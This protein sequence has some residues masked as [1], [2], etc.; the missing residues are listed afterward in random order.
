MK[1]V[2]YKTDAFK[3]NLAVK[4]INLEDVKK[5]KLTLPFNQNDDAIHF[6]SIGN[7][8][9]DAHILH[10]NNVF[11]ACDLCQNRIRKTTG[12]CRTCDFK[13]TVELEDSLEKLKSWLEKQEAQSVNVRHA[14]DETF[15]KYFSP[16]EIT[17]DDDFIEE[18]KQELSKRAR[19]AAQTRRYKRDF[20][21]IC[22]YG[23][24]GGC[25]IS[26]P[27]FCKERYF[28]EPRDMRETL[29]E[30]IKDKKRLI[31]LSQLCGLN[32]RY[33]RARYRISKVEDLESETFRLTRDYSPWEE[34][35]LSLD[36]LIDNDPDLK[37]HTEI[38]SVDRLAQEDINEMAYMLH[39][40]YR[41]WHSI[42]RI[43]SWQNQSMFW[44][45]ANIYSKKVEIAIHLS[46]NVYPYSF[47]NLEKLLAEASSITL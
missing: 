47:K 32:T 3:S 45:K 41:N 21:S 46:K 26:S 17:L 22:A 37:W 5:E 13:P 1:F 29:N 19:R 25:T 44:A 42:S 4:D 40:L 16:N 15:E 30:Q 9:Q 24:E 14:T 8:Y 38:E 27:S 31:Q 12:G 2:Q 18:K 28:I 36:E 10:Q 23:T 43:Q 20:C 7:I 39:L 34:I 35:T 33:E 11:S 6:L